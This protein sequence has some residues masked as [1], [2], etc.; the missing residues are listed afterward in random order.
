MR[1]LSDNFRM[2]PIRALQNKISG[3]QI[4]GIIFT[5]LSN[6]RYLCGF[7]GSDGAL[8]VSADHA[9][10]LVD[11]R[12]TTQAQAEAREISV[13]QYQSKMQGL[14]QTVAQM[15]LSA[16]GF[17][18]STVTVETYNDLSGRLKNRNLVALTDQLRFLRAC[19]DSDEM[20][21][22]KKAA[23]I[24]SEAI[25][26]L[27]REIKPGWTEEEAALQLEILAR[28]AGAQQIAFDTIVAAGE[29][30]ALPH[31][32]PTRRKFQYGDF[33]VIDFGVK[34]NGYCSD[35]TCTF[36]FGEL[37]EVQKNAYRAVQRAHDEAIDLVRAGISAVDVDA[38]VRD[39]LGEKYNPYFVHGTG[40]GVGLEVHEPPRLAPNSPDMLK[41]GM[42]VT[43]EPGVY[44][45]GLWGIRIEDT[46]VVKE[47]SCEIITK[48]NKE[49]LI[50]E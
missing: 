28:R 35:E 4:D 16:I 22:M 48:M 8:V 36:A 21:A 10:L 25:A 39:I 9:V 43:I 42:V 15:G 7:S 17:E 40:H 46:V 20:A 11:G 30:S 49:L 3:F 26:A 12:Y 31:A 6:I 33:V 29:N 13:V 45:P 50:I 41:P 19:K 23:A 38:L 1:P 14:E 37:T 2:R 5:D 47:K 34:Y 44:Y 18:A 32:K 27:A 24:G